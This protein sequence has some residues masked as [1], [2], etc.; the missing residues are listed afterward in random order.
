VPL[1]LD[2]LNEAAADKVRQYR[3]AYNNRPS[4]PISL[5]PAIA[6]TSGHLHCEFVRL[7]F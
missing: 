2:P 5:M 7:L 4:N 1:V 6:S 3:A